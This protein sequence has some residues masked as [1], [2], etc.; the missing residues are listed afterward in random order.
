MTASGE[1]RNRVWTW[2]WHEWRCEFS[3]AEVPLP[4]VYVWWWY[5]PGDLQ[6][7]SD[8]V[9]LTV[10]LTG[11]CSDALVSVD[12]PPFSVPRWARG[13]AERVASL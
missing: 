2:R 9:F 4:R 5:A 3:L 1:W 7:S 6:A 12:T 11:W 13:W 8:R 10:S